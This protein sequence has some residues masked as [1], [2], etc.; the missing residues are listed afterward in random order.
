MSVELE[1][2]YYTAMRKY[3]MKLVAGTGGIWNTV[4]WIHTVEDSA[5]IDFLKGRELVII[6]GI[7]CLTEEEQISFARECYEQEAAGLVFNIGP[8]ISHVPEEVLSF[9]EEKKFP[10]F[11][12]PW[13]VRLVEFNREFCNMILQ[14]DQQKQDLCS[15]FRT[16]IFS[17]DK[18]SEYMPVL[19]REGFPANEKYCMIKCMPRVENPG[20]E[21]DSSKLFYDLRLYCERTLNRM[22]KKYVIFRHD[23][24]LTIVVPEV[25]RTEADNLLKEIMQFGKWQNQ[26]GSLYFAVSNYELQ[27]GE[28]S[29]YYETLGRMCKLAYKEKQQVWYTEEL[30]ISS[31]LLA[32]KSI[33]V[34]E[35]YKERNLGV[36]ENYDMENGTDYCN[37]LYAYLKCN[38]KMQEVADQCFL[39]RNTVSYHLKK[40]A[41]LME[42]DLYSTVDRVRLYLALQIKDILSL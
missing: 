2:I 7:K 30:G 37:I 25:D 16:A 28:L 9:A 24:Y 17:P 41:E 26:K 18:T 39:H 36:L 23:I 38:G 3:G 34:L 1:R 13:E 20:E 22:Q 32:V 12:L 14:V 35:E 4:S 40:I 19:I 8:Y 21:Y 5:V 6:T 10:V 29:E 15:A 31:L 33:H 42:C 11:T 27:I